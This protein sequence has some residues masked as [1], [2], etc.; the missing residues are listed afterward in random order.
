MPAKRGVKGKLHQYDEPDWLP[1]ALVSG[2]DLLQ[3]FM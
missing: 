2:I 3:D 1:L